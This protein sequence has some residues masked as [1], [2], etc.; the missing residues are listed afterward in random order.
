LVVDAGTVLAAGVGVLY[1]FRNATDRWQRV[2]CID[3][4]PFIPSGEIM[5]TETGAHAR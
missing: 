4:P 1:G 3:S 2:L 5:L